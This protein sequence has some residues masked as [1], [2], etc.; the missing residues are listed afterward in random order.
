[1]HSLLSAIKGFD[2]VEPE[3]AFYLFPRVT[4]ILG[5][6]YPN[7][8]SL[9]RGILDEAGVALVPGDSFGGP[10]FLRFSYALGEEEIE[11]GVSRISRLI[12]GL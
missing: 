10:G 7:S 2:C 12:E 4:A 5:E 8:E 9:A 3:G 1:M 6:R 11:R